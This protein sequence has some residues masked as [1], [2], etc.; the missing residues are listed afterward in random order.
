MKTAMKMY[1]YTYGKEKVTL[2]SIFTISMILYPISDRKIK[3]QKF[4]KIFMLVSYI[5]AF[6]SVTSFK[7]YLKFVI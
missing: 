7:L 1:T 6:N 2:Y 4:S 5:K 3:L